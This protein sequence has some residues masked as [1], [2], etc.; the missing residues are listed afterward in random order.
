MA[1]IMHKHRMTA[2][3]AKVFSP[4]ERRALFEVSC[5]ISL[6][7]AGVTLGGDPRR[8]HGPTQRRE[9]IFRDGGR[10][11]TRLWRLAPVHLVR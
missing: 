8:G 1:V 9:R 4:N 3:E 10:E 5:N 7:V 11:S 6:L 2:T